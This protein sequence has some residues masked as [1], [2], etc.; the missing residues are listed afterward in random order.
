[1]LPPEQH[2]GALHAYVKALQW[3]MGPLGAV[4]TGC[5]AVAGLMIRNLSVLQAKANAEAAKKLTAVPG[6]N[7]VVEERTD[8]PEKGPVV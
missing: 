8:R 6:E 4:S 7:V 5:A 2:A 1:M 3:T